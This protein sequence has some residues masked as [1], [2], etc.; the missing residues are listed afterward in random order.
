MGKYTLSLKCNEE[1]CKEYVHYSY[2]TKK[3]YSAG[4]QRHIK[5]YKCVRHAHPNEVLNATDNMKIEKIVINGKSKKYPDLKGLFWND[6]SG[7]TYGNGWKA[8]ANDFPEGTKIKIT[9][10]I[11]LP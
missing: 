1:G 4:Y 6:S 3:E 7:F 11:I 10:E 8:F 9:A 2:D 5:T